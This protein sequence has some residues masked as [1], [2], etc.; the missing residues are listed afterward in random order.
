MT[1]LEIDR[2]TAAELT[3]IHD[4][5]K[6]LAAVAQQDPTPQSSIQI[7]QA[8]KPGSP[9]R[10]TVKVYGADPIDA[11]KSAVQLYDRLVAKYATTEA[12]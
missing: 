9:P 3:G 6:R 2:Y 11:A 7:E 1:T 5:L 4:S 12:G 8:A 10:I